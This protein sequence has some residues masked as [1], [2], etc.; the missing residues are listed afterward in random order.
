[1]KWRV[2]HGLNAPS[3]LQNS[4]FERLTGV[5]DAVDEERFIAASDF[6]AC[7]SG[8]WHGVVK[9]PGL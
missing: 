9:S 6:A 5:R 1:M 3:G 2:R 8:K 4:K 7:A